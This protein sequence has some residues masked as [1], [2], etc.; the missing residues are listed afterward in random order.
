MENKTS[1]QTKETVG[2]ALEQVRQPSRRTFLA[3]AVAASGGAALWSLQKPS[4]SAA[5]AERSA[6][7]PSIVIVVMFSS[8]GAN[9][10]KETVPHIVKPEAE[11]KRQLSPSHMRSLDK[12]VRSGPIPGIVGIS[13]PRDSSD[14][15]AAIPRCSARRRNSIRGRAGPASGKSLRRRTLSNSEIR[16]SAWCEPQFPAVNAMLT[17]ATS[18]TMVPNQPAYA[19]A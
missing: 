9:L 14:A 6:D 18:S 8:S 10:G 19:I 2:Q 5:A 17:S 3:L 12:R 13:T 1:P 15:C 16:L 11:W 7:A 4:A